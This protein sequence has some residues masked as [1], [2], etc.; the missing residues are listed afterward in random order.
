MRPNFC[1]KILRLAYSVVVTFATGELAFA[2][3]DCEAQFKSFESHVLPALTEEMRDEFVQLA[4]KFRARFSNRFLKRDRIRASAEAERLI[5][6][7][8]LEKETGLKLLPLLS[9]R[10]TRLKSISQLLSN[11]LEHAVLREQL[12]E[13]L[14]EIGYQ[15]NSPKVQKWTEFRVRHFRGLESL[16]RFAINSA[17][18]SVFGLPLFLRPF[19]YQR[20]LLGTGAGKTN[21]TDWGQVES[22]IRAKIELGDPVLM[23]EIKMEIAIEVARRIMALGVLA[24]LA[25]E[26][27]EFAVPEWTPY[28]QNLFAK[29]TTESKAE[30]EKIAIANWQDIAELL[31]GERP[32]VSS[33][34]YLEIAARLR[35]MS[36]TELS[37]HVHQGAPLA[38]VK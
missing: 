6:K 19:Q 36:Q 14:L 11:R 34:E 15:K 22:A 26:F 17:S 4:P 28:K 3:L 13:R 32:S 1:R 16:K 30:L 5:A 27:L 2:S 7:T 29:D 8:L 31:S 25:D 20:F 37:A 21:P 10:E 18:T 33:P 38:D 9:G 35:K 24:I 12:E 23:R